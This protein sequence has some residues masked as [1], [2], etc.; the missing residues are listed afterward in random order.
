MVATHTEEISTSAAAKSWFR[1]SA[2]E[3]QP[4]PSRARAALDRSLAM[5]SAFLALRATAFSI[6][7]MGMW[8]WVVLRVQPLGR[9]WD[10]ALPRW[11][12]IPGVILGAAGCLGMIVCIALFVVRGRGT[13][14]IFDAP[15][16]FVGVGPYRYVRNPMYL[17]A[18]AFFAGY[19]LYVRS[20]AVLAF[21]AGWFLLIHAFVLFVEEPGLRQRFG[22]TYDEYCKRVPRWM[23]RAW[24]GRARAR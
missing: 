13:P 6:A 18:I 20:S 21:A 23:P 8:F 22:R 15:Q 10:A 16:R 1:L 3:G 5:V 4:I 17:S 19:G 9:E 24:G 7:F 11:I 14:A 12:S 2:N